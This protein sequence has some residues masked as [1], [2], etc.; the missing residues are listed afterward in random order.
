MKIFNHEKFIQED[1]TLVHLKN[2]NKKQSVHELFKIPK[3]TFY[4]PFSTVVN[5]TL[6]VQKQP[7]RGVLW[8]KG[9]LKKCSKFAG[10]HHAEVR[11]Q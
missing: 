6:K 11:F 7:L 9:V 1:F 2:R 8:E 5:F 3:G 10:E 4:L